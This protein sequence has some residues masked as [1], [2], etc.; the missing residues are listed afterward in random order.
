MGMH[1]PEEI[2]NLFKVLTGEEWPEVDEDALRHLGAAWKRAS[3]QIDTQLAPMINNAVFTIRSEFT[4]EAELAFA[5]SMAAFTTEPPY[6]FD[7]ATKHY[8]TVGVFG[9]DT[10]TMVQYVKLMIIAQLIVLLVEIAVMTALAFI[11]FG[12]TLQYLAARY[13]IVRFLINTWIGRLILRIVAAQIIG[14]SLQAALD[15]IVQ[16]IQI[17]SGWRDKHDYKLTGQAAAVGSIGG[18][19]SVVLGPLSLGAGGLGRF[20]GNKIGGEVGGNIGFQTGRGIGELTEGGLTESLA[21]MFYTAA[22]TGEWKFNPFAFTAGMAGSLSMMLGAGLGHY[23]SPNPKLHIGPNATLTEVFQAEGVNVTPDVINDVLHGRPGKATDVLNKYGLPPGP[24][25]AYALAVTSDLIPGLGEMG[26]PIPVFD[27]RGWLIPKNVEY[28]FNP[29]SSR[30][31]EIEDDALSITDLD[32]DVVSPVPVVSGDPSPP[33]V[34]VP[35]GPSLNGRLLITDGSASTDGPHLT[36]GTTPTGGR[37]AQPPVPQPTVGGSRW[38]TPTGHKPL[39]ATW[40]R[41]TVP[42]AYVG[43][44]ATDGTDFLIGDSRYTPAEFTDLI[45]NQPAWSPGQPV[46]LINSGFTGEANL[47]EFASALNS[48]V[49]APVRQG[50][51]IEWLLYPSDGREPVTPDGALGDALRHIE[52][53]QQVST[54]AHPPSGTDTSLPDVRAVP[55]PAPSEGAPPPTNIEGAPPPTTAGDAP[56]P[57]NLEGTPPLQVPPEEPL[58]RTTDGPP[59]PITSSASPTDDSAAA[60]TQNTSPS[61]SF[62]EPGFSQPA[63]TEESSNTR[64]D[65]LRNLPPDNQSE[66]D[67]SVLSPTTRGF[68]IR[69]DGGSVQTTP[70]LDG[71]HDTYRVLDS[72]Q[73]R[74]EDIDEDSTT[75]SDSTTDESSAPPVVPVAPPTAASDINITDSQHKWRQ[76]DLSNSRQQLLDKYRDQLGIAERVEFVRDRIQQVFDEKVDQWNGNPSNRPLDEARLEHIRKELF[77]EIHNLA[78]AAYGSS[79][80]D[81]ATKSQNFRSELEKRLSHI[82][83]LLQV[84]SRRQKTLEDAEKK[85]DLA[86]AAWDLSQGKDT[87]DIDIQEDKLRAAFLTEISAAFDHTY[88]DA[89]AGITNNEGQNLERYDKKWQEIF[90]AAVK[91]LPTLFEQETELAQ[92]EQRARDKVKELYDSY[93]EDFNRGPAFSHEG[94]EKIINEFITEI[95]LEYSNRMQHRPDISTNEISVSRSQV[96][97]RFDALL[98]DLPNRFSQQVEIEF[99]QKRIA[100]KL[101]EIADSWLDTPLDREWVD[102]IQGIL[103][104]KIKQAWSL[105][106]PDSNYELS[107][108]IQRLQGLVEPLYDYAARLTQIRSGIQQRLEN[109][110]NNDIDYQLTLGESDWIVEHLMSVVDSHLEQALRGVLSRDTPPAP[111]SVVV[112][113]TWQQV[114]QLLNHGFIIADSLLSAGRW[115]EEMA[116]DYVL[117]E[118]EALE[119]GKAFRQDWAQL[120]HQSNPDITDFDLDRWLADEEAHEN[121]FAN[122]VELVRQKHE[123][124]IDT[125]Q[126]RPDQVPATEQQSDQL[127]TVPLTHQPVPGTSSATPAPTT[128]PNLTFQTQTQIFQTEQTQSPEPRDQEAQ[129]GQERRTENTQLPETDQN[130]AETPTLDQQL[131]LEEQIDRVL[132]ETAS[133]R[134]EQSDNISPLWL[135]EL[136]SYQRS[137]VADLRSQVLTDAIAAGESVL[138]SG[139]IAQIRDGIQEIESRIAK[140]LRAM[141]GFFD[142]TKGLLEKD[143]FIARVLEDNSFQQYASDLMQLEQSTMTPEE[144]ETAL[145][146]LHDRHAEMLQQRID[147]RKNLGKLKSELDTIWQ[148]A[149]SEARRN[150]A[151]Q[152]PIL[153]FDS[154]PTAQIFESHLKDKLYTKWKSLRDNALRGL[155]E[156]SRG[157]FTDQNTPEMIQRQIDEALDQIIALKKNFQQNSVQIRKDIEQIFRI[158]RINIQLSDQQTIQDHQIEDPTPELLQ[159]QLDTP[160]TQIATSKNTLTQNVENLRSHVR[161]TL[162]LA[163][164]LTSHPS[165]PHTE[166]GKHKLEVFD[167]K[168]VLDYGIPEELGG[169]A[170]L[171]ALLTRNLPNLADLPSITE[172]EQRLRIGYHRVTSDGLLLTLG[173]GAQAVEVVIKLNLTNPRLIS[174]FQSKGHAVTTGVHDGAWGDVTYSMNSSFNS[175]L[176]VP[177]SAG[178]GADILV[179]PLTI[180]PGI[181]GAANNISSSF[182]SDTTAFISH[183]SDNRGPSSLVRWDAQ[184]MVEVTRVGENGQ[185]QTTQLEPPARTELTLWTP[186]YYLTAAPKIQTQRQG[187]GFLPKN[188]MVERTWGGS[189]LF[190]AAL[191]LVGRANA[192]LS[193]KVRLNLRQFFEPGKQS[194]VLYQATQPRGAELV[195]SDENDVVIGVLRQQTTITGWTRIG[196]ASDKG[197]LEDVHVNAT[198]A[199]GSTNIGQSSNASLSVQSG[200]LFGADAPVGVGVTGS[201]RLERTVGDALSAGGIGLGVKVGRWV[202]YTLGYRAETSTVLAFEPLDSRRIRRIGPVTGYAQVRVRES[203]AVTH[204]LPVEPISVERYRRS[205]EEFLRWQQQ[206]AS[207]SLASAGANLITHS[208]SRGTPLETI[209]EVDES[210]TQPAPTPAEARQY[211]PPA[212]LL[213]NRGLGMAVVEDLNGADRLLDLLYKPLADRGFLPA[214]DADGRYVPATTK[215]QQRALRRQFENLE[216]LT[217]TVSQSGI[218]AQFEAAMQHGLPVVLTHPDGGTISVDISVRIHP[219][220]WTVKGVS[221]NVKIVNLWIS[222]DSP[223]GSRSLSN[224]QQLS[225]TLGAALPVNVPLRGDGQFQF[226]LPSWTRRWRWGKNFG[227]GSGTVVNNVELLETPGSAVVY[228]FKYDLTAEIHSDPALWENT[229]PKPSPTEQINGSSHPQQQDSTTYTVPDQDVTIRL[230]EETSSKTPQVLDAHEVVIPER[231][232][233]QESIFQKAG[234][235]VSDTIVVSGLPEAFRRVLPPAFTDPASPQWAGVRMFGSIENVRSHLEAAVDGL[236]TTDQLFKSGFFRDEVGTLEMKVELGRPQYRNRTGHKFVSGNIVFGMNRVDSSGANVKATDS[237]WSGGVGAAEVTPA[238]RLN[239]SYTSTHEETQQ[240]GQGVASAVERLSLHFGRMYQFSAD[241]RFTINAT[242]VKRNRFFDGTTTKTTERVEEPDGY[243]FWLREPDAIRLYADGDLDMPAHVVEDAIW[244]DLHDKQEIPTD[245]IS[246]LADKF[247]TGALPL[248]TSTVTA[249]LNRHLAGDLPLQETTIHAFLDAHAGRII[250]LSADLVSSLRQKYQLPKDLDT[251]LNQRD[252]ASLAEWTMLPEDRQA[253]DLLEQYAKNPDTT[254]KIEDIN[255]AVNRYLGGK[256]L[257]SEEVPKILV[258]KFKSGVLSMD[259]NLAE[260]LGSEQPL[261]N[262]MDQLIGFLTGRFPLSASEVNRFVDQ[263]LNGTQPL[264]DTIIAQIARRYSEG[265]LSLVQSTVDRL[266]EAYHAGTQPLPDSVISSMH[267]RVRDRS[268]P[269]PILPDP[270]LEMFAENQALRDYSEGHRTLNREFIK[271]IEKISEKNKGNKENKPSNNDTKASDDAPKNSSDTKTS[272]QKS[273]PSLPSYMFSTNGTVFGFG[274]PERVFFDRPLPEVVRDLLTQVAPEAVGVDAP[275]RLPGLLRQIGDQYSPSGIRALIDNLYGSGIRLAFVNPRA[276]FGAELIQIK[277]KG[278]QL[279]DPQYLGDISSAGLENYAYSNYNRNRTWNIRD[280]RSGNPSVPLSGGDTQSG[281]GNY[282]YTYNRTQGTDTVFSGTITSTRTVYNWSGNRA[283]KLNTRV[284]VEVTRTPMPG[285]PLNNAYT[286]VAEHVS[287]VGRPLGQLSD[288]IQNRPLRPIARPERVTQDVSGYL[289]WRLPKDFADPSTLAAGPWSD[290]N[291]APKGRFTLPTRFYLEGITHLDELLDAA[292]RAVGGHVLVEATRN[293]Q[294]VGWF[295]G[296]HSIRANLDRIVSQDGFAFSGLFEPGMTHDLFRDLVLAGS[297]RDPV[298]LRT[299]QNDG[300]G[301]F[302]KHETSTRTSSVHTSGHSH[303]VGGGESNR[304]GPEDPHP[305][306][307]VGPSDSQGLG[308]GRTGSGVAQHGTRDESHIKETG[309]VWIIEATLDLTLRSSKR[310]DNFWY[311]G[312]S[313]ERALETVTSKVYLHLFAEDAKRIFTTLEEIQKGSKTDTKNQ[314]QSPKNQGSQTGQT[315]QTPKP[316]GQTSQA[317]SESQNSR[318]SNTTTPPTDQTTDTTHHPDT[319]TSQNQASQEQTTREQKPQ[320][321]AS[322]DQTS[323]NPQIQISQ[324]RAPQTPQSESHALQ[325]QTTLDQRIIPTSE[326]VPQT[327]TSRPETSTGPRH[328]SQE[329]TPQDLNTASSREPAPQEQTSQPSQPPTSSAQTPQPS[330]TTPPATTDQTLDTPHRQDTQTPQ[331]T[332]GPHDYI[333]DIANLRQDQIVG[334]GDCF[335][336]AVLTT[337]PEQVLT[338]LR[339][340]G[341]TTPRLEAAFQNLSQIGFHTLA[342]LRRRNAADARMRSDLQAIVSAMR[343]AAADSIAY[344]PVLASGLA[345]RFGVFL[346]DSSSYAPLSVAEREELAKKV[347]SLGYWGYGETDG[348]GE[349]RGDTVIADIIPYALADALNLRIGVITNTG[350]TS[351]TNERA[352]IFVFHVGGE[353]ADQRDHYNASW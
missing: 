25:A 337:A 68:P 47:S 211:H 77:K 154:N 58:P 117:S 184:W 248:H 235:V 116:Q 176:S 307:S 147:A 316:E 290:A 204:N 38:E 55:P 63:F 61:P 36:G 151:Q 353:T 6:Y 327:P 220:G 148:L 41:V 257:L 105:Y 44:V 350:V 240:Q 259:P 234:F 288:R 222:S 43:I 81:S 221:D 137:L 124:S 169:V 19:L 26:F 114:T 292:Q 123:L 46:V 118:D 275:P 92:F 8:R 158:P 351:L 103:N 83:L 93:F 255:D 70:S 344:S 4:G 254:P 33:H 339:R 135:D 126:T 298:H 214:R 301:G 268:L 265:K 328:P 320:N 72:S 161:Q 133:P 213:A 188:F 302:L 260:R 285:R 233:G 165:P 321:A 39:P 67:E 197:H 139:R 24:G 48:D 284:T 271:S 280:S 332:S 253:R 228:G 102:R 18:A 201:G 314:D 333:Q 156:R 13:A 238:P 155:H 20:I 319:Q 338:A 76:Y 22:V 31:Q 317:Q 279:T 57:R 303:G 352:D 269:D 218:T 106:R 209:P 32:T 186:H 326:T 263:H 157:V 205:Q 274:A 45:R 245:T 331:D 21:E 207:P 166:E 230:I 179:R 96:Q 258:Q 308:Y 30:V 291:S 262:A 334:D 195:I 312:S 51:T 11:S 196:S 64:Q 88:R 52:V 343:N 231:A 246:K 28:L 40:D 335:F 35:Q 223:G 59:Q 37:P 178:F 53:P 198:R 177:I 73:N 42:G 144:R 162:G 86:S 324:N 121:R 270:I 185:E 69:S 104:E 278:N 249:I 347:R 175:S 341:Y 127:L 315:S 34:R 267:R 66:Q 91:R 23:L 87:S 306:H 289:T 194:S 128:A 224:R 180:T 115:F 318:P 12:A 146:Q 90:D 311:N 125:P 256:F 322:H 277:V 283:F 60:P 82:D 160:K 130:Q 29:D 132:Q 149:L 49:I 199:S 150:A 131:R 252:E 141:E 299:L 168:S 153:G 340:Q 232:P 140:T 202:G 250:N 313:T 50:D 143:L 170:E 305:G 239:G 138:S 216:K 206:E 300:I 134:R 310:R 10:A 242:N 329:Q 142:V 27:G 325:D 101:N 167:P 276:Q 97:Q 75:T 281:S 227:F 164:P 330:S 226:H 171:H 98:L 247:A 174:D 346:P 273:T 345:A 181:G 95:R 294:T 183:V 80:L 191:K 7:T 145:Q 272:V 113:R 192:P 56:P 172:L 348:T 85:F 15:G 203:E 217:T 3:E 1:V 309:D 182:S 71:R 261:S 237:S 99:H 342:D 296:A 112:S 236:Y 219:E 304:L 65:P 163:P 122:G 173:T 225:L 100:K 293:G 264:P 243:W 187:P 215:K 244:S 9:E 107:S 89:T 210:S 110:L 79:A 74:P 152:V 5:D 159:S 297:L 336:V 323:V 287:R 266:L 286:Y 295:L 16:R 108:E 190:Q 129:T 208:P 2:R 212:L 54:V 120:V 109:L 241:T 349:G 189:D 136:N 200:L 94:L 62:Q 78:R 282:T 14:V 229:A 17:N 119:L 84:E 193:S 111:S 251:R